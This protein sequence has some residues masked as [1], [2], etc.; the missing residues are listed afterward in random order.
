MRTPGQAILWQISWRWRWGL[1]AAG[2]YLL[3]AITLSHVVPK[4]LSIQIGDKPLPAVGWFLG[5]PSI[6]I[7]IMLLAVFSM[8][9][10]DLRESGFTT[11]MFILPVR[12]RTLVAWPMFIGCLTVMT[13]WLATAVLVF[14]LGGIAAPLWWPAA[15][16]AY[17]LASFQALSWTPFAQRWLHV[18]LIPP[19]IMLPF[20]ALLVFLLLD[21][22]MSERMSALFLIGLVPVAFVAA[23][24]GVARARRGDPYDWRLW[25]RVV[26][27][28]A[29]RRFRAS[30]PFSS[31]KTAQ[32]WF[33]CRAHVCTVPIFLGCMLLC[34]LFLPALDP[35]NIAL[36]WR[37]LGTLLATPLFVAV[38][39]GGALGNLHDPFSRSD[40][41]TFLLTRPISSVSL[42]KGKLIAAAI[43]TAAIWVVM[44]AFTSL[45]LVRPGFLDSI[46][47][48]ARHLLVWKAIGLPLLVLVLLM[49]LTWKNMIENLWIALTGRTWVAQ[50]NNIGLVALVFCG[51]GVG[52]WIYFHPEVHGLA[53]AAVPWLIGL[54]LVSKLAL[55]TTVV[56]S[57]DRLRL[58]GRSG[59]AVIVVIWGL[60]VIGLCSIA[61]AFSPTTQVSVFDI[62]SGIALLTPFS[63]LAGAP[64]ALAWNRHR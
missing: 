54:L 28:A 22:Q 14:R 5:L 18:V 9:G 32:L 13:V 46:V 8:S 3:V 11:H 36:G 25:S 63:R 56:R 27:W 30:R 40:T 4:N 1:F 19:V 57:L 42:V 59:I 23:L 34:V 6:Y 61:L 33:E 12:T 38:M 47:E 7:N 31:W 29:K 41:A 60:V 17:L 35:N 20:V 53:R 16:L 39:A 15:T 2:A 48:A 55:A 52:L 26:E 50:A 45:L 43:C 51:G 64:L 24:S 37:F 21:I 49:A 44:L 62:V 10:H 58:V